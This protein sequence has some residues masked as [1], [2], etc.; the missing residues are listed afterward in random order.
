MEKVENTTVHITDLFENLTLTLHNQTMATSVDVTVNPVALS[1]TDGNYQMGDFCGTSRYITW[2]WLIERN[3]LLIRPDQGCVL[4]ENK[5][6]Y[7][8]S[9]IYYRSDSTFSSSYLSDEYVLLH[10]E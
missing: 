10:I 6:M 4:D 8:S 9:M 5:Y 7:R 3:P 1:C 2:F